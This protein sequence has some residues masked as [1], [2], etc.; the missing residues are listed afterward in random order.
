MRRDTRTN[1]DQSSIAPVEMPGLDNHLCFALYAASNHMTRLFVP[2]LKK[3]GVTYPQY[4][5]LVVLWERGARGVGDL[6][7]ALQMDLGSLSPML[8]RLEAKGLV[9]RRRQADDER[10][11]LVDLTPQ[12]V[13]LRKRTEQMLGEFYCFLN[14][15]L[16][17]LFDLKDRLRHFVKSAGPTETTTS[18]VRLPEPTL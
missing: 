8:K 14:M 6:A 1:A 15:P 17:E 5:V 12:G 7:T 3:L 18:S 13:S 10:R 11:V 2:F 16:D 9:T 4:L